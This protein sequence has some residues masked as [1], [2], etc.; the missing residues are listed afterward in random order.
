M[1]EAAGALG[2]HR[3]TV[4][5]W[6]KDG[7]ST[8]DTRRPTLIL[9]RHLAAFLQARRAKNKRPCGAAQ[10][11]CVRCRVPVRPAGDMVEYKPVTATL[12][13]LVALCPSCESLIY[14]RINFTKLG[15]VCASLDVSIPEGL[16]HIGKGESPSVNSD[17]IEVRSDHDDAQRG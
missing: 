11:Y 7:L 16:L 15:E 12:G 3:N 5:H 9:G 17:L 13:N 6:I 10:I 8:I 2:V 4:R 1:E 14:R